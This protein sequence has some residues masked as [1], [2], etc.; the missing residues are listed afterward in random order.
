MRVVWSDGR[1]GGLQRGV[2][3]ELV[4][5]RAYKTAIFLKTVFLKRA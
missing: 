1:A 5:G 2:D 4:E 3:P